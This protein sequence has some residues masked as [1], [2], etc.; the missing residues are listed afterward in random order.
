MSAPYTYTHTKKTSVRVKPYLD[1]LRSREMTNREVAG[2]LGIN[3]QHLSRVLKEIGFEKEAATDR[4]A[5]KAAT[6]AKKERIAQAAATMTPEEAAKACGVSERTIYRYL[7]KLEDA[8][9]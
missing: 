8:K 5:A 9:K 6:A 3:E 2:L 7:A 4:A 1:K